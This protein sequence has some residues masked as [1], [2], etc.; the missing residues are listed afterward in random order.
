MKMIKLS[1]A[2]AFGS[3]LL[4]ATHPTLTAVHVVPEGETR[5]VTAYV[6]NA[7]NINPHEVLGDLG[8]TTNSVNYDIPAETT[9]EIMRDV[10]IVGPAALSL[11]K[12]TGN[13]R[14]IGSAKVLP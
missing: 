3:P 6:I 7:D 2:D 10:A 11:G 1:G 13:L 4:L 8:S 5:L 14:I 12:V 9:L